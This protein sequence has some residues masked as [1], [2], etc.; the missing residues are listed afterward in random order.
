MV[1][2]RTVTHTTQVAKQ[3]NETYKIKDSYRTIYNDRLKDGRRSLKVIGW[4]YE[5]YIMAQD[6]LKGL[7]YE[8]KIVSIPYPFKH[9][10]MRSQYRLHVNETEV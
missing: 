10:M 8:S 3:I 1:I 5:H 7:G 4:N 6:T 2:K 9:N